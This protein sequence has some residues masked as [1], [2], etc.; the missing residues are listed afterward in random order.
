MVADGIPTSLRGSV[1]PLLIGNRQNVNEGLYEQSKTEAFRVKQLSVDREAALEVQRTGAIVRF[2]DDVSHKHA[3]EVTDVIASIVDINSDLKSEQAS[4]TDNCIDTTEVA[5]F[6]I[7]DVNM[8]IDATGSSEDLKVGDA[9][10]QI[11]S[12]SDSPDC[13]S[14][15]DYVNRVDDVLLEGILFLLAPK[16]FLGGDQDVL[17]V[18]TDLK[19]DQSVDL[20][21]LSV[22]E[23]RLSSRV[24]TVNLIQW[25]IPRTFPTLSFFQNGAPLNQSLENVL[26]AYAAYRPDVGYVQGMSFLVAVLLL[27]MDEYSAFQCLVNL[28]KR[29]NQ[30]EFYRLNLSAVT[31]FSEVFDHYFMKFLPLL[32]RHFEEQ[33]M[34]HAM[35][36]V[37][38]NLTVFTKALPLECAIRI[39]DSFLVEGEVFVMRA[40][41]GLLRLYAPRLSQMTMESIAP[42]LMRLP[43]ETNATDLFINIS[44][45]KISHGNYNSICEKYKFNQPEQG[46]APMGTLSKISE[47][48]NPHPSPS[49]EARS[50]KPREVIRDF[51]ASFLINKQDPG[52]S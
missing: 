36:L 9:E 17:V 19:I 20:L 13:D 1:W 16:L 45:I 3:D 37:D 2:A 25:D 46:T 51:V 10:E 5:D 33:G 6:K 15:P 26:M 35:F 18:P 50:R 39:W 29:R 21:R 14:S 42:F 22:S 41:I 34:S 49:S 24:Q 28:M 11:N 4:V 7:G 32:Y 44:Q 27:Q 40:A 47:M 38:W 23:R 52:F 43:E 12:R 31:S 30:L 8:T 48:L